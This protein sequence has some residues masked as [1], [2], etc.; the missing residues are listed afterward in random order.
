[1]VVNLFWVIGHFAGGVKIS[2]QYVHV[3]IGTNTD[4]LHTLQEPLQTRCLK[5]CSGPVW[6]PE[7][8]TPVFVGSSPSTRDPS[9]PLQL[10]SFVYCLSRNVFCWKYFSKGSHGHLLEPGKNIRFLV[11]SDNCHLCFT[12]IKGRKERKLQAATCS[13]FGRV[14]ILYILRKSQMTPLHC[15]SLRATFW[16]DADW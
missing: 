2:L 8:C 12:K 3:S 6:R 5:P 9:F 16:T 15:T 13:S 11:T 10:E 4:Y 1:M 7:P 14:N